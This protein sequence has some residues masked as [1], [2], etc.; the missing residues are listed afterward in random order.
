MCIEDGAVRSG[1]DRYEELMC[2]GE[3]PRTTLV[4]LRSDIPLAGEEVVGADV[5]DAPDDEAVVSALEVLMSGVVS[6]ACSCSEI[7]LASGAR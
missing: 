4:V 2:A 3:K 5:L 7:L 1:M 6:W